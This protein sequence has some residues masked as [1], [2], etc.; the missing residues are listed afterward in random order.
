[1]I[2]SVRSVIT[3]LSSPV[4]FCVAMLLVLALPLI[5]GGNRYA[6]LIGLEWLALLL[7]VLVLARQLVQRNR[8]SE[9]YGLMQISG[10]EWVLLCSPFAL[11]LVYLLPAP[12]AFVAWLGGDAYFKAGDALRIESGSRSLSLVPEV[13]AGSLLALLPAL[14]LYIFSRTARTAWVRRICLGFVLVAVLESCMGLMQMGAYKVLYFGAEFAHGAI[15]TF[16]N[17]NHFANFLVMAVPLAI[18]FLFGTRRGPHEQNLQSK[19]AQCLIYGVV[20]FIL[21]SAIVASRSR[22]GMGCLLVIAVLALLC[23]VRGNLTGQGWVRIGAIGV[24]LVAIIVFAVYFLGREKMGARWGLGELSGDAGLRLKLMWTSLLTGL[25]FLPFGAGPGG[26]AYV[27]PLFQ[28]VGLL[29]TVEYAHNDYLQWL[30]ELGLFA[31]VLLC[32]AVKLGWM[33]WRAI[34]SK[35][36]HPAVDHKQLSLQVMCLVG[37]CAIALHSLVDF[38]F[39][40][41][42][43][44]AVAAMLLGVYMRPVRFKSEVSGASHLSHISHL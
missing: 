21:V 12:E 42:A 37:F 41:P 31:P 16:A 33:Q 23:Q 13:T 28:P 32:I 36:N 9:P 6:A 17:T 24:G 11:Y 19:A 15:G 7:L 39:R 43:N 44:A 2:V 3:G 27:Y 18:Y 38:N 4:I 20:L 34:R 5:R 1:M 35:Q 14:A 29:T 22:A 40:I 8:Q 26:F 30:V 25:H 10:L